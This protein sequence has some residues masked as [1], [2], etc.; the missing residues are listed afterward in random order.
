MK[1]LSIATAGAA[2]FVLGTVGTPA[3]AAIV[4]FNLSGTLSSG[5]YDP[6]NRLGAVRP[7]DVVTGDFS[8]DDQFANDLA[9]QPCPGPVE[10][11]GRYMAA[12]N[13]F[14][15]QVGNFAFRLSDV[16]SA[17]AEEVVLL[18]NL[19]PPYNPDDL[20]FIVINER[21][22]LSGQYIRLNGID[23]SGNALN[24]AA[25]VGFNPAL[26]TNPPASVILSYADNTPGSNP[27]NFGVD[28]LRIEAVPEPSG[29]TELLALAAL[30]A[31]IFGRRVRT[32]IA[33]S[34]CN[35]GATDASPPS[36]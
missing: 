19:L 4:E 34:N 14:N 23:P 7:G 20:L 22:G 16:A 18:D 27:L 12:I 8:I 10:A 33:R 3:Q 24:S 11:C 30:G 9:G 36:L 28:N 31:S 13:D 5:F 1:N 2:L 6:F 17:Q 26:F 35:R 21:S 32:R 25:L 15:L 29:G